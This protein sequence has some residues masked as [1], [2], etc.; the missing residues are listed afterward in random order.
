M[1]TFLPRLRKAYRIVASDGILAFRVTIELT[2]KVPAQDA[3]RFIEDRSYAVPMNRKVSDNSVSFMTF[4]D[5]KDSRNYGKGAQEKLTEALQELSKKYDGVSSSVVET[6][7]E[8]G[9]LTYKT[10]TSWRR[11]YDIIRDNGLH[12]TIHVGGSA[13]T[14]YDFDDVMAKVAYDSSG[15][16]V[17]WVALSQDI[18]NDKRVPDAALMQRFVHPGYRRKNLSVDMAR[19][20]IPKYRRRY[21]QYKRLAGDVPREIKALWERT[22]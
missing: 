1:N 20:M 17:A 5:P 16:P 18:E 8:P 21:P 22:A 14:A 11:M 13:A 3:L 2:P 4:I 19:D 10:L 6:S 15:T 9:K 12:N 7:F